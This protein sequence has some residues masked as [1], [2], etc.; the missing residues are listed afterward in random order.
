MKIYVL[1]VIPSAECRWILQ[2]SYFDFFLLSFSAGFVAFVSFFEPQHA[3]LA[4]RNR[5]YQQKANIGLFYS[6]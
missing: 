5:I 3:I 1:K 2:K 6:K 4:P